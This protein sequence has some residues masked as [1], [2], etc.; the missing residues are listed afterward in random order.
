VKDV[1][2]E[3]YKGD[4]VAII[5]QNGS[6]KTTVLKNLL[7][8][9]RPT[10]G[11]VNVAG[12]DT[13]TAAVS[14]MAK[15]VGF[16]LQNPDQQL[17]ADTVQEEVA[18]GPRNLKLDKDI[19]EQRV[20]EALKV[21]GMEDK[22]EEFPPAL[23]KG[24]RAKVVIAS[25]LALDPEIIVLDEPTTG[26]DYK[27]CHQIMQIAEA[28]NGGLRHASYGAGIRIRPPGDRHDRRIRP[29]GRKHGERV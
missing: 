3:I 24:D 17:F 8:L 14:D 15:H 20:A 25:A 2:F 1:S 28:L 16:V 26:Q 5:G 13:K 9:L 10:T 22:R 19:I 21:V 29:A 27:G 7:G 23:S 11:K 12:L 18:Y 6:G 4:F